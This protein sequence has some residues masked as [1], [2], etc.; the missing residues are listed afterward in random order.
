MIKAVIF[1][2]DGVLIDAKEWHYESLND[3]LK[4]FGY[5][6]DRYDHLIT[7]DG[8][9]TKKKLEMISID[10]G[11]PRSLHKLINEL[12]QIYTQEIIL[13]QCKPVFT[14]EYA[15]SRLK[16]EGYKLAVASNSIRIT[17]EMM[18]EKAGLMPY[19]DLLLSNQDVKKAK[20]DPEIYLTAMERLGVSPEECLILEDNPHGLAAARASGANIM[21]VDTTADVNYDKIRMHLK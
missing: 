9:P 1:D 18:M 10:Q 12:K 11:L 4:L 14:C 5:A 6:V 7:Y 15:L 17:V 3:A 20:P 2:M 8:L 19:L 16:S 21:K 13:K